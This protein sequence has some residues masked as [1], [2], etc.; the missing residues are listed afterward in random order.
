MGI[1]STNSDVL[2]TIVN[3]TINPRALICT[4]PYSYHSIQWL[5]LNRAVQ[6]KSSGT[7]ILDRYNVNTYRIMSTT[8]SAT[9]NEIST[10]IIS[11]RGEILATYNRSADHLPNVILVQGS[12]LDFV[13]STASS[14]TMGCIVNAANECCLGGGGIDGAI[15]NAG[16]ANLASDRLRLPILKRDTRNTRINSNFTS[17][18]E[19]I[20]TYQDT[21]R[22][23]NHGEIRCRTGS[24]VIT[25]PG[26]Y[27]DL[28]VP[29][30][31]HA[32][33]PDFHDYRTP[34]EVVDGYKLL[35][36]AYQTSLDIASSI[37]ITHIAFCL[38]SAGIYRH[39]QPLER[40]VQCG[41]SA[42]SE[43]R[44]RPSKSV[45][46]TT[47]TS[48]KN[49]MKLKEIYVFAYTEMECKVLASYGKQVFDP[50]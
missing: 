24:A 31:V 35:R 39:E 21:T 4:L 5:C 12:V 18:R 20:E 15:S 22:Y 38:L 6:P 1:I 30:V 33:G 9:S 10:D 26:N 41:L 25:G 27:G 49:M 37:P 14:E 3:D 43:W 19:F 13:T 36:S 44:R 48:K 46:T 16:G 32:V 45:T 47:T 29:Y 40:I 34:E 8:S 23:R 2:H 7:I 17:T 28:H 42:I 50:K 11:F